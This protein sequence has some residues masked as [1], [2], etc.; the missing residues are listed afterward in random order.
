MFLTHNLLGPV[1]EIRSG[2][3]IK[4]ASYSPDAINKKPQIV[5]KC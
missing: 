1:L 3:M 5:I 2:E 4:A